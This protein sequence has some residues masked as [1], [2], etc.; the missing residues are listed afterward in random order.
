M[1]SVDFSNVANY[2]LFHDLA[3]SDVKD[4]AIIRAD[5]LKIGYEIKASTGHDFIGNVG[6]FG[7]AVDK[8]DQVRTLFRTMVKDMFGGDEK[9]VPD[10]V[11]EAMKLDD[12]GKGKPLTARRIRAVF[13]A[14]DASS[15]WGMSSGKGASIVMDD[16]LWGSDLKKTDEAGYELHTRMSELSKADLQE[17]LSDQADDL[18]VK[19]QGG[20]PD[21]LDLS[22]VG[23]EFDLDLRRCTS[24]KVNGVEVNPPVTEQIT[25]DG[26]PLSKD[27]G[28]A[29][30]Q[31]AKF[32]TDDQ[33]ATFAKLSDQQKVK[34]HILMGCA[35]QGFLGSAL[36]GVQRSFDPKAAGGAMNTAKNPVKDSKETRCYGMM[37]KPNG[38]ILVSA[39]YQV[40]C[41][42]ITLPKL[43]AN[44]YGDEQSYVK[45]NMTVTLKSDSLDQFA[46]AKAAL[47]PSVPKLDLTPVTTF[48]AHIDKV[49]EDYDLTRE[50]T[51]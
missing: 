18:V 49:F 28:V 40:D 20:A 35:Q 11:K 29:R 14:I 46:T 51:R 38:D 8:N 27:P 2:Q 4:R 43:N 21:R 9:N 10:V 1:P 50:I 15:C 44:Y 47:K 36:V 34:V 48:E 7:S 16:L 33:N 39:Y 22:K 24:K 31:F 25:L 23:E 3:A 12:Y 6:R 26:R 19:G 17:H 45:Y 32:I 5:A 30:D 42:V 41:P 37:R 13:S